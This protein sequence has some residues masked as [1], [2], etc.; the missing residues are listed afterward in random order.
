MCCAPAFARID[1][2]N[3]SR[4][5]GF[6]LTPTTSG[7]LLI[8][9]W[10]FIHHSYALVAQSH[11]LCLLD[12]P[13]ITLRFRD[14][15]Y[16]YD[17]WRRTRA[18]FSSFDEERLA[19]IASPE[20]QFRPDATLSMRAERPDFSAPEHGRKFVFGTPEHRV[21]LA[22]NTGAIRSA[23]DV[24]E[25]VDVITP[26]RWTAL[27]YHRFGFPADRV[28][29]VPHG[30]DPRIVQPDA[31]SRSASRKALGVSH[32]FVFMSVGAMTPNKGID[33]LLRAFDEVARAEPDAWLL[34]K[35][36]DGLYPSKE[37][38]RASM[39]ELPSDAR[40]RVARRLIYRGETYSSRNMAAFMRAADCYV[41]PYRAEGFNMPVLEAAASGVAVI[42]TAGGPTDEFTQPSFAARI[43]SHIVPQPL[44]PTQTGE[45]L[46]PDLGHLIELMR[47][48][49]ADRVTTQQRGATAAQYVA[50]RLTWDAVTERLLNAM[51]P[52]RNPQG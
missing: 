9:G 45:A 21:L 48:A 50:Q 41:A 12:R 23:H 26:S 8:E 20:A 4:T 11:C 34:L 46:A 25:T 52:G 44:S 47:D 27:A 36:A 28:H 7:R 29:V 24:A 42:C 3:T 18:I 16:Y 37:F 6:P 51:F 35:G 33:L 49:A 40:E 31:T 15:P 30:I 43:R 38:L 2:A 1:A 10:R 5:Q 32:C 19:A 22:Q 39:M 14:L 13:E 17:T